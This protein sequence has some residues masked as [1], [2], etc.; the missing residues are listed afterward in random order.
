MKRI[1]AAC[2]EQTIHFQLKEDLV[3]HEAAVEAVKAEVT[4]YK[5]HLER[6][7]VPYVV[8]SEEKQADDSIVLRLKKQYNTYPCG[9]Y[10]K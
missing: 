1:T 8:L 2:L 5:A 6:K 10:L 4:Q 3:G 7:R 9:E